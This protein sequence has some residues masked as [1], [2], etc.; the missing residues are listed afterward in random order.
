MS[1][2]REPGR[3]I[4]ATEIEK[5]KIHEAAETKRKKMELVYRNKM[6]RRKSFIELYHKT[7]GVGVLVALIFVF[8]AVLFYILVRLIHG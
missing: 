2:Y 3:E 5:A 1:F 4:D 8:F 7:D 6:D